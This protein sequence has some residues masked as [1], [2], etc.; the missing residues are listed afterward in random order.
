MNSE[1]TVHTSSKTEMRIPGTG[2]LLTSTCTQSWIALSTS[3][4][5]SLV[6]TNLFANHRS[7]VKYASVAVPSESSN[8]QKKLGK[9]IIQLLGVRLTSMG[10]VMPCCETSLEW[11]EADHN[12]V[13]GME[14][15]WPWNFAYGM[16]QG[17]TIKFHFWNGTE[18]DLH[19]EW[20]R[21]WSEKWMRLKIKFCR[22]DGKFLT[23]KSCKIWTSK[24][25]FDNKNES[26]DHKNECLTMTIL[27]A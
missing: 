27:S 8:W 20:N 21:G 3:A 2:R 1:N 12:F 26:F 6:L 25:Q 16:K 15:V 7:S 24:N 17:L 9:S 13:I 18:V 23:K 10:R 11:N 4:Y 22:H 14:Q 5:S 19:L